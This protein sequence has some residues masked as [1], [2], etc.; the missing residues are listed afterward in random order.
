MCAAPSK[1]SP[2]TSCQNPNRLTVTFDKFDLSKQIVVADIGAVLARANVDINAPGTSP[3]CMSFLKDA[4][5]PPVM[6]AL[7]L[8]YEGQAA[9][10][11]Q[12]FTVK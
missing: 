1:T 7:G 6:S 12:F 4:D 8:P 11:Q 3:G 5:C 9:G 10:T 2:P